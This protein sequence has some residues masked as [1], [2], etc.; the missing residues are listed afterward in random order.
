MS[1]GEGKRGRKI[2]RPVRPLGDVNVLRKEDGSVEIVA[3]FMPDADRI[4]GEKESRAVL[5][6]DASRSMRQAYGYG[7]F[8][9]PNY[10][11]LV[12]RKLGQILT[13][14]TRSGTVSMTYWAMG[15][16]GDLIEPIGE[17]DEAG[18]TDVQVAGPASRGAWGRHTQLLPTIK[19]V[20]EE[21]YSQ[22]EWTM[23]VII[24]DGIIEDEDACKE[25]CMALGRRLLEEGNENNLKL[26]LIGVGDEVDEEQLQNFDDMFEDTD[27]EEKVDLWAARNAESM[28]DEGDIISALFS[29]MMS[30][31]EMDSSGKVMD[32]QGNVVA[33]YTDGLMGIIR[34]DLPAGC[35]AFTVESPN[36]SVTQP[37]NA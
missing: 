9:I 25:Y 20:V 17:L 37:I 36:I 28:R 8:G 26:I 35:T 14:V 11:E 13:E 32:D 16:G 30:E 21:V 5:A 22:V 23:G 7:G 34:F 15:I 33:N 19:Y 29:E 3:C 31:I 6:L 10:V 2:G 18:C 4:V 1:E 24:T 12:A 27:L